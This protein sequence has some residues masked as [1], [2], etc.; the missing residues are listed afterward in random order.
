MMPTFLTSINLSILLQL[1]IIL[2]LTI[3][4]C[5]QRDE[6]VKCKPQLH[7]TCHNANPYMMCPI[8]KA[9]QLAKEPQE[10]IRTI[11]LLEYFNQEF[12]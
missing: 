4:E 1:D 10:Q 12:K 8:H 7:M 6:Y 3:N 5:L 9:G 11:P 2:F